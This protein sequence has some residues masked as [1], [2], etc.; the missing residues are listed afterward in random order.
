MH[1]EHQRRRRGQ[2]ELP[3][4]RGTIGAADPHADQ[5]ARA[6]ADR[7]G[8]A[9]TIAGA[10]LPGQLWALHQFGVR[11]AVRTGQ[12]AENTPGDPGR[13]RRQQPPLQQRVLGLQ[14]D[15]RAA[16]L[17]GE[18]GIATDQI[19]QPAARAPQDQR[20]VRF[21][22]RRQN[23]RHAA[24]AHL[25]GET[26]RA[27]G[28]EQ[29]HRRQVERQRQRGAGRHR[30]TEAHGEVARAIVTVTPRYILQQR[31]GMDQ[32]LVHGHGIEEGF[33]RRAGR[34]QGVDHVDMAEATLIGQV[35]RP[36]IGAHRH[37]LRL[38]HQQRGRGAFRQPCAPAQQQ[39]FQAPLQGGIDRGTDQRR[40]VGAVQAP[41]Q[42]RGQRRLLAWGEQ[43]RLLARFVDALSRPHLVL[44]QPLQDLVTGALGAL[45]VTVGAQAA[46]GLGQYGEQ[47][48]LGG[49]QVLRRLAQVGPAGRRHPLQ[50]AA[51]GRAVQ[52]EL[53]DLLF[54]QVPLQLCRAPQLAQLAR[55]G[56]VVR[57]EQARHLHR[58]GAA[59]RHHAPTTQVEPGR[60]GQGHGVDP[61]V[62]IEPAVLVGQQRL[63]VQRRHLV[64]ADRVTPYAIGVGE[65]P[66]R[67]AVLGQHHPRQIV[68][69]H[70]QWPD[71]I[72][73]P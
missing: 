71:S 34:T 30:A 69:G 54:R 47:R 23:Q 4:N 57:V 11:V 13:A 50:G 53:Q 25:R 2:A 31:L 60:P 72:G 7:P 55:Q 64:R 59:P 9:K 44:G 18:R 10:C 3:W 39:V 38:H 8:I 14:A 67:R 1:L 68:A 65:P 45:G 56:A 40:A 29:L 17:T 61:G 27:I 32:A 35:D 52:V 37:A 63:E 6:D 43:Q 36:Q 70:R 41:G 49:R 20:Q 33:E 48:R 5:V 58:Q 22:Q 12:A 21:G 62:L 73:Q 28:L 66:Q 26:L 42:Q 24:H 51:E 16:P 46:G 15:L 19:L